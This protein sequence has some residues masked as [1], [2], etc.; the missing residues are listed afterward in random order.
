MDVDLADVTLHIDEALS[1]ED[2][3]RLEARL[4][5][6]DG[7]V[8]VHFNTEKAHPHLAVIEFVPDKVR[9]QELLS[10][11]KYLGHHGELVGL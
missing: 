10:I 9:P 5:E 6:R 4:R 2:I 11:V 8:S 1:A 3:A 7:V